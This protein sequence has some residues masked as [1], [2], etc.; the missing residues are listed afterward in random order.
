MRIFVP[1]IF[2]YLVITLSQ[3]LILTMLFFSMRYYI[4]HSKWVKEAEWEEFGTKM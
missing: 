2:D 3:F 4:A 1:F